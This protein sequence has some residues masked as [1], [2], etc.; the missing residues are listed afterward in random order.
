L[1]IP[2]GAR[3]LYG[4]LG[5]DAVGTGGA[6]LDVA[7]QTSEMQVRRFTSAL[8]GQLDEVWCGIPDEYA[9]GVLRGAVDGLNK[10]GAPDVKTIAFRMGAY[11]KIGST[12]RLFERLGAVAIALLLFPRTSAA[13]E[14]NDRLEDVLAD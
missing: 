14:L 3:F 5:C 10:F 6:G 4:L 12:P 9:G 1:F 13:N 8:A 7:V 11:G 2:V